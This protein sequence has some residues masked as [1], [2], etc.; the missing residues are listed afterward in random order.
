VKRPAWRTITIVV[1]HQPGVSVFAERYR[2]DAILGRGGM[3]SVS[4]A[5]D[6]QTGATLALK[7]LTDALPGLI[8]PLRGLAPVLDV[9]C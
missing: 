9:V 3:G 4:R 6:I 2:V 7:Q 8:E 1:E 5:T